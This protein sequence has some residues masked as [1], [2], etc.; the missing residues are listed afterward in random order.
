M[1]NNWWEKEVEYRNTLQQILDSGILT[2]QH[3]IDALEYAIM[4]IQNEID[5]E[6]E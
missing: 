4:L 1:P 2:Y 3:E 6:V 5:G